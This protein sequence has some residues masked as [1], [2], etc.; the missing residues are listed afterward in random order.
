MYVHNCCESLIITFISFAASTPGVFIMETIIE[1]V[2]S[3]LGMDPTAVR[4]QNLYQKG[5]VTPG[6]MPLTYC[7]I[8]SL[9]PKL[10]QMADVSTRQK[11]VDA[12]NKVLARF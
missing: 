1:H 11:E 6:G 12:F 4:Q 9:F 2:A 3:V 5:Q 8:A 7:S 10:E